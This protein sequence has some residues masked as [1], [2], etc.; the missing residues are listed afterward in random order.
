[1]R[2]SLGVIIEFCRNFCI[3]SCNLFLNFLSNRWQTPQMSISG[4]LLREQ[5]RKGCHS[6][7]L[8]VSSFFHIHFQTPSTFLSHMPQSFFPLLGRQILMLNR[9]HMID[10]TDIPS[11]RRSTFPTHTAGTSQTN[12]RRRAKSRLLLL[13]LIFL[14]LRR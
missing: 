3:V 7:H 5:R 11:L 2:R 13:Q 9:T 1:M 14:L 8:I 4:R 6:T 10:Y 12:R